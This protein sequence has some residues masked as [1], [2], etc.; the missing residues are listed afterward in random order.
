MTAAEDSDLSGI[1]Y[2]D[3]ACYDPDKGCLLGTRM[4]ILEDI[5]EWINSPNEDVPHIYFLSGVAGSG[6]SAIAHTVVDKQSPLTLYLIKEFFWQKSE[7]RFGFPESKYVEK[8]PFQNF[9]TTFWGPP[10]F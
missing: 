1:P 10:K 2:A 8:H 4:A 3:G 7:F 6:K 5:S 9:P